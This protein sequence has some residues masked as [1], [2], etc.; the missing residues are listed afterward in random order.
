MFFGPTWINKT[1]G[2]GWGGRSV[3]GIVVSVE[4]YKAN[5][6]EWLST[7]EFFSAAAPGPTKRSPV[8]L[9]IRLDHHGHP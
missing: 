8:E 5:L 9:K 2:S 3:Q 7:I 4:D 1:A 6:D